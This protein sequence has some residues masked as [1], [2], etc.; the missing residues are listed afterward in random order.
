MSSSWGQSW[1]KSFGDSW[2]QVG[3]SVPAS[4]FGD[5]ANAGEGETH[6]EN[7][8]ICDRSGF[9]V[10]VTEDSQ[11]LVQEYDG[12]MVRPKDYDEVHPQRFVRSRSRVANPSRSPEADDEFIDTNDIT[13]DS[14]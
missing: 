1:L 4:S 5:Y 10:K 13:A 9:R 3:D 7:Y 8:V 11:G 12:A 2:G 14:F 6:I